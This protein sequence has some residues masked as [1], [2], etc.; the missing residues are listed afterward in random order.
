[1]GHTFYPH[2]FAMPYTE[3]IKK[4]KRKHF[5]FVTL[6]NQRAVML[7]KRSGIL[8]ISRFQLQTINIS[9]MWC[10]CVSTSWCVFWK[11][12]SVIK[13]K[14]KPRKLRTLILFKIKSGRWPHWSDE[15]LKITSINKLYVYIISIMYQSQNRLLW[16]QSLI[17]RALSLNFPRCEQTVFGQS[18][19]VRVSQT[20][21]FGWTNLFNCHSSH[22][23][24]YQ[25]TK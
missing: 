17:C 2:S 12:G 1:M 19:Y 21:Y 6:I 7:S 10:C 22:F 20:Y 23:S 13:K 18:E 24:N 8:I 9:I 15:R 16:V 11:K 4:K 25:C 14:S 5:P 3:M